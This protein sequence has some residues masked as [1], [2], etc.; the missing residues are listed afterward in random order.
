M[1]RYIQP[2]F[3]VD[4]SAAFLRNVTF[5]SSTYLNGTAFITSPATGAALPY[6]LVVD[7]VGT[8]IQIK[9]KLLGS[10]AFEASTN[11]VGYTAYNA[12]LGDYVKKAGD[13]MTGALI[14][15]TGGLYVANNVS[16]GGGLTVSG[17]TYIGGDLTID[18]CIFSRNI[19]SIDV[20][21]AFIYLNTGQTGTPPSTMQS[22]IVI[23]RG[24]S[25]PYVFVYDETT[26]TF[27]VGQ[28]PLAGATYADASLQAVATRE[29]VPVS[30]GI[31]F[32]NGAKFIL[33]TSTGFDF[34][35]GVG[36]HLPIATAD[37]T[38]TNSLFINGGGLLVSRT[39]GSNA[40]NSSTYVLQTLFDSSISYLTSYVA[41]VSTNKLSSVASTT[42]G[43]HSIYSTT[44]ANT[45]YVKQI[46]A[47]IGA[48]ITSDGS[49]IT[50]GVTG[51]AGYV[52]R[53]RGTFNGT[54][55]TSYAIP[56]TTHALGTGPFNIAIFEFNEQV[57]TGVYVNAAGD[58]SITWG[59]GTITDSSCKFIIT[60]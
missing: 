43:T 26:Q 25:L 38:A 5:N 27:R 20:S 44:V 59:A 46:V 42:G 52:S 53:Y 45:A 31:P 12:S 11:Y 36:L 57:Y 10:M 32:W 19:E 41:S 15:N 39:L 9:S 14:I 40:F 17:N 33:S 13:T 8:N 29:D 2:A 55:Q 3:V 48:S 60:G 23:D 34:T 22:G 56:A 16:V 35:P 6:A 24:T 1:A 58:V 50:I 47:G 51:T 49:I 30:F 54:T 18:G 4:S 37:A 7:S 28:A 21:A